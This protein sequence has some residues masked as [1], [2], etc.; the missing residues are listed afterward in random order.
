MLVHLNTHL[1]SLHKLWNQLQLLIFINNTSKLLSTSAATVRLYRYFVFL[2]YLR[3]FQL[4]Q[5]KIVREK[6]DSFICRLTP[7]YLAL[8]KMTE[9]TGLHNV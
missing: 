3:L 7:F 9:N 8:G 4:N 1:H 6:V 5:L 2:I